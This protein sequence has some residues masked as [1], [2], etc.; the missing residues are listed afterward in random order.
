[1]KKFFVFLALTALLASVPTWSGQYYVRKITHVLDESGT[2]ENGKI[3]VELENT[4]NGDH[5]ATIIIGRPYPFSSIDPVGGRDGDVTYDGTKRGS[6][7][8]KFLADMEDA[9]VLNQRVEVT[10]NPNSVDPLCDGVT[11]CTLWSTQIS[12]YTILP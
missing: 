3:A 12:A 4:P 2:A 8:I 6:T 9:L 5:M 11:L 10:L 1:M 7:F